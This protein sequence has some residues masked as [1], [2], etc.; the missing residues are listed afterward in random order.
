MKISSNATIWIF[1]FLCCI[2]LFLSYQ[3]SAKD[4]Y[5]DDSGGA[6]FTHIQDAIDYANISDTIH[7]ASGTYHENLIINKTLILSGAGFETTFISGADSSDHTIRITGNNV[8]IS[9]FCIDNAIAKVNEFQCVFIEK[10]DFCTIYNNKI[11]QGHLGVYLLGTTSDNCNNNVISSNIIENNYIGIRLRIS[12]DNTINQNTVQSCEFGVY[13]YQSNA[14]QIFENNI[15]NNIEGIHLLTATTNILYKNDFDD[16]P[17]GNA[18]DSSANKWNY[19]NQ[20][21]YW[22][23]YNDYDDDEDGIG[24]NPYVIDEDSVDYYPLGDFLTFDQ[25]P[26]ATIVSISPSPA[27]D[28]DL[29]FFNGHSTDDGTIIEWEWKSS[30]NGVFGTSEDCSSSSLAIGTHTI[31]FRVRDDNDQWSS[32]DTETLVINSDADPGIP[33]NNQPTATIVSVNPT[34]SEEGD[35]VSF[36][37]YG[38]DDGAIAAYQ[39]RSSVDNILSSE[40]S[41]HISTLSVGTHTIYFRVQDDQGVWSDEDSVQVTIEEQTIPDT[42]PSITADPGGPYTGTVNVSTVFD[43]SK[44]SDDESTIISYIWEFGDDKTGEGKIITHSYNKT[45]SFNVSLTVTNELGQTDVSYTSIVISEKPAS[46]SDTPDKQIPDDSSDTPG[47]TF[48]MIFIA[49]LFLYFTRKKN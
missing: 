46:G 40:A 16:N 24:D 34:I 23:D 35:V 13:I 18:I 1:F 37:G 5:V 33:S 6:D 11:K 14:N 48:Y 30:I 38:S 4:I 26:V 17:S 49:V 42:P 15:I 3:T 9:G 36:Q 28:D 27:N 32:Y 39:W 43:A 10:A 25:E 29:V 31:R 22:D 45:G 21:N 19:N 47:F 44:S 7:V 12:H 20:G 2:I 41:F 8:V